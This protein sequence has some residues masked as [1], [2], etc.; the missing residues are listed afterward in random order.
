[1]MEVREKNRFKTQPEVYGVGIN[2]SRLNLK[3]NQKWL[4]WCE[5]ITLNITSRCK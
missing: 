2:L 5:E 4:V 1:M 3:A